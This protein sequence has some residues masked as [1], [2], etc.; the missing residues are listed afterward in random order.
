MCSTLSLRLF[1]YF[2]S[3]SNDEFSSSDLNPEFDHGGETAKK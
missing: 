2:T 3:F 1:N